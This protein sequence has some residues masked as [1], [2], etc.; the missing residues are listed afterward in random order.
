MGLLKE[1]IKCFTQ[2]NNLSSCS[3]GFCRW[4]PRII[5]WLQQ[6]DKGGRAGKAAQPRSCLWQGALQLLVVDNFTLDQFCASAGELLDWWVING[7]HEC[8]SQC[9]AIDCA[10]ETPPEEQGRH[11]R[12]AKCHQPAPPSL[13]RLQVDSLVLTGHGER[14]ASEVNP[15][16]CDWFQPGFSCCATAGWGLT[17][18]QKFSHVQHDSHAGSS[19]DTLITSN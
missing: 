18:T 9:S 5:S 14:S 17:P 11:F 6:Q 12:S 16:F 19:H 3:L 7:W 8:V 10:G 15:K 4:L 2:V 1:C 13:H